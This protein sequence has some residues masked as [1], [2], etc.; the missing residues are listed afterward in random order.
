MKEINLPV[1]K[2]DFV[3]SSDAGL[4]ASLAYK[5]ILEKIEP[6]L[7]GEAA[8]SSASKLR[9]QE[10]RTAILEGRSVEY[11]VYS[12]RDARLYL[13]L[14]SLDE[15]F[16]KRVEFGDND[17]TCIQN[18]AAPMSLTCLRAFIQ[19]F[20]F[21]FD[22][23]P[24]LAK[25][26]D[27][28]VG[29]LNQMRS[30]AERSTYYGPLKYGAQQIFSVTGPEQLADRARHSESTLET[31][32]RGANIPTGQN[33]RFFIQAQSIFYL[34]E[35]K[36]LPIG[37]MSKVA[38]QL[39][40]RAVNERSFKDGVLLGHAAV[41]CLIERVLEENQRMP[42]KWRDLILAICG[43][44]RIPKSRTSFQ[45]WWQLL[46]PDY[47]HHM[48]GWLAE[49]DLQLFLEILEDHGEAT[50]NRALQRM[51]PARRRFLEGLFESGI[52]T[53]SR[54]VLSR[55]ADFDVRRRADAKDLPGYAVLDG[56]GDTSIIYLELDGKIHL[57]EGT[58]NFAVR[59]DDKMP[60]AGLTSY[61]RDSFRWG[62]LTVR[63]SIG[64]VNHVASKNYTWQRKLLK[65]LNGPGCE[66]QV[67]PK[68]VL[69]EQDYRRYRELYGMR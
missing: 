2:L 8:V 13:E 37:Q 63:T 45:K 61:D 6:L 9:K 40:D 47:V 16:F 41:T 20:F 44:P 33:S 27:L 53:H 15:E 60:V 36:A 30:S 43:D 39:A 55:S 35:L 50:G 69:A 3:L 32:A 24:V 68:D 58:H 22:Q 19:L 64:K 48:R 11:I 29:E 28:I 18:A 67:S 1:A 5:K 10:I 66:L 42:D 56:S 59:V 38:K 46:K 7:S 51:F 54:L 31:A 4:P 49:L 17:F 21:R 26:A 14:L 62:E 34:D 65:I 25:F 52:V 57:L 23:L 12:R